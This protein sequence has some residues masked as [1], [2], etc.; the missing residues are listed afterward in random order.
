M[1]ESLK[2]RGRVKLLMLGGGK[3]GRRKKRGRWS[4]I[5]VRTAVISY[6][7]WTCSKSC[8]RLKVEVNNT[9][10]VAKPRRR[11]WLLKGALGVRDESR[12]EGEKE[13]E[14]DE[15]Q[16]EKRWVRLKRRVLRTEK[17]MIGDKGKG[18]GRSLEL[19]KNLTKRW[20]V[21]AILSKFQVL[22]F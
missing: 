9:I 12:E 6:P 14:E 19:A 22:K 15:R 11:E 18:G 7:K 8:K 21:G 5:E 3:K 13:E 10:R 4:N 20:E 16:Q 2:Y 17:K 1:R